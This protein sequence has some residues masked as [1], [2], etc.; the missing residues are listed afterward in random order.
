MPI[1]ASRS[2]TTPS[3]VTRLIMKRCRASDADCTSA[4]DSIFA[5]GSS[6]STSA[7]ACRIA[8]ATVPVGADDR[9]THAG[10]NHVCTWRRKALSTCADGT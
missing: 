5:I 8:S 9:I 2:A 6:G 1:A 7:T 3:P 4:I 10:E